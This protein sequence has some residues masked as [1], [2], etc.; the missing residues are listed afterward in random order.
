MARG[1]CAWNSPWRSPIGEDW[2][3]PDLALRLRP[4][5]NG[6]G[7]REGFSRPIKGSEVHELPRSSGERILARLREQEETVEVSVEVLAVEDLAVED[8]AR[9]RS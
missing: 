9:P 8:F 1:S 5:P 2:P 3:R 4:G 7:P 6:Q